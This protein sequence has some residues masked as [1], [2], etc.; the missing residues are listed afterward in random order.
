MKR[1]AIFAVVVTAL[2]AIASGD[3]I[4]TL[5]SGQQNTSLLT[6]NRLT[7]NRQCVHLIF[8]PAQRYRA[9]S[10]SREQIGN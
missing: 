5:N 1:F 6:Q 9:A 8:V 7:Q 2:A 3:V 4:V 10:S